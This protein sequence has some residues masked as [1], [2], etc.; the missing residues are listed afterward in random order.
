MLADTSELLPATPELVW[1]LVAFLL[2]LGVIVLVTV[3]AV[4]AF[5]GRSRSTDA[6][7]RLERL[8]ARVSE[9]EERDRA[10]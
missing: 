5:S 7:S 4:R 10:E 9:L 8:E 1:G 2:V 6:M 3:L